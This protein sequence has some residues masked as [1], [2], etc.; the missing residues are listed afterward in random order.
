MQNRGRGTT[1]RNEGSEL[2]DEERLLRG[3]EEL[4]LKDPGRV[5]GR[6]RPPMREYP[7]LVPEFRSTQRGPSMVCSLNTRWVSACRKAR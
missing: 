6:A 5:R 2:L 7:R 4:L 1:D 3:I